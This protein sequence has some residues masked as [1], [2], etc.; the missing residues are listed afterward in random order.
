MMF[1]HLS[2]LHINILQEELDDERNNPTIL[3]S[4]WNDIDTKFFGQVEKDSSKLFSELEKT[5]IKRLLPNKFDRRP[6]MPSWMPPFPPEHTFRETPYHPN[7]VTNPRILREM[8]VKEGQ[9]AE[10]A[11]RRLTGVIKVD[12]SAM[13]LDYLEDDG[14]DKDDLDTKMTIIIPDF[15]NTNISTN[16]SRFTDKTDQMRSSLT[17]EHQIITQTCEEILTSTHNH[18]KGDIDMS[19]TTETSVVVNHAQKPSISLKL[20]ISNHLSSTEGIIADPPVL[21]ENQ[22]SPISKKLDPFEL[23]MGVSAPFDIINFIQK[24]V[25]MKVK[26]N[27]K[28]LGVVKKRK[29]KEQSV[30]WHRSLFRSYEDEYHSK[31]FSDSEGISLDRTGPASGFVEKEYA[32][33]LLRISRA[34][35]AAEGQRQVDIADTGIVNWERSRYNY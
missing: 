23:K 24:R 9:L 31:I 1:L 15:Q 3:P 26:S 18:Q 34:K 29:R 13:F 4:M 27:M 32:A 17:T 5:S 11:L 35:N 12:D 8:I 20:S 6:H 16:E 22:S 33:A 25:K 7:R 30:L 14:I 19:G 10:Q 28:A 2:G 21:S